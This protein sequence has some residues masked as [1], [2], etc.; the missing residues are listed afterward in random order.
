MLMSNSIQ[1]DIGYDGLQGSAGV[2]ALS[3]EV[4]SMLINVQ[5]VFHEVYGA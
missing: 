4:E 2:L 3:R 5:K 1:S